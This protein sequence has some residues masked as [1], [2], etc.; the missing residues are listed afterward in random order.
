MEF[1]HHLAGKQQHFAGH[2][3]NLRLL[4]NLLHCSSFTLDLVVFLAIS[5]TPLADLVEVRLLFQEASNT[6]KKTTQFRSHFP[7]YLAQNDGFGYLIPKLRKV[8]VSR[9][10]AVPHSFRPSSSSQRVT[11]LGPLGPRGPWDPDAM[12]VCS[13]CHFLNVRIDATVWQIECHMFECQRKCQN[14]RMSEHMCHIVPP[15]Y[16]QMICQKRCRNDLFNWLV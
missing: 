4:L 8:R 10:K 15:M 3:A 11:S 12:A 5:E 1:L 6:W 16:F 13:E 2:M 9:C 14:G 7:F